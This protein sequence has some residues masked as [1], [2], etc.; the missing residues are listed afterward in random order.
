LG[1]AAK[2]N[3]ILILVPCHRVVAAKGPGGW[4]AFGSPERKVRLLELEA[5]TAG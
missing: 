4:S 2:A 5:L 1:R 3:P